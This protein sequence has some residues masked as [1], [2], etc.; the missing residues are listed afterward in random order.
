MNASMNPTANHLEVLQ[1]HAKSFRL[2]SLFLSTEQRH[3]VAE[4]YAFCRAVDDI[5]DESEDRVLARQ[6]LETLRDALI[7][8]PDSAAGWPSS[9]APFH[10]FFVREGIAFSVVADLLEGVIS[11]LETVRIANDD[12]LLLY[13]YRVAGTVGL[14]M[15]EVLGVTD[16]HAKRHAIDLGIGMQLTNICRDVLEDAQNDRVYLP[17]T[18]LHDHGMIEATPE[19]CLHD[20][21]TVSGVVVE[22][23]DVAEQ[24][25]QSGEAGMPFLPTRARWAILVASRLYRAIGRRLLN[26][27]AGNPLVGRT[28]VPT[29]SKA[30][31]VAQATFAWVAFLV[32]SLRR[33]TYE[34]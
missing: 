19:H 14:M 22:L 33:S 6:T 1:T 2:A 17:A 7:E 18:R 34:A 24:R 13:C 20:S 25:Y 21:A 30:V 15:C 8:D 26:R 27:H 12:E 10:G 3:R 28:I 11:D 4:L 23:L 9:L 29:S 16:T 32:A 31:L 5:A